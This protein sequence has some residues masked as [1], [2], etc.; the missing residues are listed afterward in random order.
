MPDDGDLPPDA[1][2]V[3]IEGINLDA[4]RGEAGESPAMHLHDQIAA[5]LR[6]V[7]DGRIDRGAARRELHRL[8]PDHY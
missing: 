8:A 1:Y 6:D 5:V 3:A 4:L 7:R 2:A